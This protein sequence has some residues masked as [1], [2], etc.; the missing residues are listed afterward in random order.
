MLSYPKQASKA[1][2]RAFCSM[3]PLVPDAQCLPQHPSDPPPPSLRQTL[4]PPHIP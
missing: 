2:P 4:F 1:T 3:F